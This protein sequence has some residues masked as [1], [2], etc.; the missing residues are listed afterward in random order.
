VIDPK[1]GAPAEDIFY[2]YKGALH[3]SWA[4]D[5]VAQE[6]EERI[7]KGLPA[8]TEEE[9]AKR[10]EDYFTRIPYKLAKCRY[11]SFERYFHMLKRLGWVEFTGKEETSYIQETYPDAPPCV[12]YRL[13]FKGREASAME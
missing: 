9:A 3:R 7:K 5:A 1:R 6:R 8:Y 10:V 11:S 4:E 12:Y 2:Y 13:S